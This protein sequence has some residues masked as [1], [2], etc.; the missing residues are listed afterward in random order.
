MGSPNELIISWT[1]DIFQ[2][3]GTQFTVLLAKNVSDENRMDA[4]RVSLTCET[5]ESLVEALEIVDDW[6]SSSVSD[7]RSVIL[8]LDSV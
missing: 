8:P 5:R 3:G 4:R 6:I 7:R 1:V 2:Q